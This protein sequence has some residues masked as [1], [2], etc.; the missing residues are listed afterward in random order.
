M[1]QDCSNKGANLV[2]K[3]FGVITWA[4]QFLGSL[5]NLASEQALHFK[6]TRAN[7]FSR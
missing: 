3:L 2:C 6:W 4:W 5:G 1:G 7:D